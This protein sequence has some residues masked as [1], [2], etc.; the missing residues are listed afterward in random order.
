[1]WEMK[2][3]FISTTILIQKIQSNLWIS[4]EDVAEHG[5]AGLVGFFSSITIVQ[6]FEILNFLNHPTP[7]NLLE[8]F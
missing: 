6:L 7:W 3:K 1:M 5:D 8:L 4:T 2:V